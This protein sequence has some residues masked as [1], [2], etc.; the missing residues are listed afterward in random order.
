MILSKSV[1]LSF[2]LYAVICSWTRLWLSTR[3]WLAKMLSL[4]FQTLCY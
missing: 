3:S 2:H 4:N 1:T